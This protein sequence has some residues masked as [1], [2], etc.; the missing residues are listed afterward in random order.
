MKEIKITNTL[1]HHPK[2]IKVSLRTSVSYESE[3]V[4]PND[5]NILSEGLRNTN[6]IYQQLPKHAL[7]TPP[8][9]PHAG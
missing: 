3:P 5:L 2:S 6:A 4:H 8:R 9:P 7:R 1:I